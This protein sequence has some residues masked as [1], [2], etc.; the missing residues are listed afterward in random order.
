[1]NDCPICNEEYDLNE[2]LDGLADE[3]EEW[4]DIFANIEEELCE[5]CQESIKD[6]VQPVDMH[7]PASALHNTDNEADYPAT[8]DYLVEDQEEEN[9]D[10]LF[11]HEYGED[12]D[13]QSPQD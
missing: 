4:L 1:M 11:E 3:E 6:Q 2:M 13:N 10:G 7:D 8:S 5:N 9:N 12:E